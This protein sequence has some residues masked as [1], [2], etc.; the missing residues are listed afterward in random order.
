[1]EGSTAGG[2]VSETWWPLVMIIIAGWFATDVWRWLG[3]FAG[4]RLRE[5][6]EL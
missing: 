3:V 2:L 6:G 1:M 4:G 5:D